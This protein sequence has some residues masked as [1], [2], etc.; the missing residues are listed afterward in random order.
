[1]ILINLTF[2]FSWALQTKNSALHRK[3]QC[4]ASCLLLRCQMWMDEELWEDRILYWRDQ[5]IRIRF[6]SVRICKN[7]KAIFILIYLYF[8]NVWYL[9]IINKQN[10]YLLCI[11]DSQKYNFFIIKNV[12]IK[13]F[14]I[15]K[16]AR[17]TAT[18]S[19]NQFRA[20]VQPGWSSSSSAPFSSSS[21]SA[22]LFPASL[23]AENAEVK[24]K[25]NHIIL[26]S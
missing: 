5:L 15:S 14:P 16:K 24:V 20:S 4:Q 3:K 7:H 18:S 10:Q 19:K 12:K 8:L 25:Q 9:R 11:S 22:S 26:I 21:C 2:S 1:M 6:F 23:N 17:A 13:I